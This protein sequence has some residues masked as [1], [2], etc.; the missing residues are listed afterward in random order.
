[1][2]DTKTGVSS[3]TSAPAGSSHTCKNLKTLK[4]L[5]FKGA[6]LSKTREN[7]TGGTM[8]SEVKLGI[9]SNMS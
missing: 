4:F 3:P 5:T 2:E 7:S 8:K 1:M 6:D 9:S